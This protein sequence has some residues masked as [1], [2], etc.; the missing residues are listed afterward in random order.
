MDDD[1]INDDDNAYVDVDDD[2]FE[3]KS[4]CEITSLMQSKSAWPGLQQLEER[5][6][7]MMMMMKA[8]ATV[9]RKSS[10]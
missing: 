3:E 10:S 1:D 5:P 9:K 2:D 8:I 4:D 6:L 7:M